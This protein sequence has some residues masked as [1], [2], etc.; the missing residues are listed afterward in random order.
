MDLCIIIISDTIIVVELL[1]NWIFY[2]HE[3][4]IEHGSSLATFV[5]FPETSTVSESTI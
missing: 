1:D 2:G 5:W 3:H 4:D